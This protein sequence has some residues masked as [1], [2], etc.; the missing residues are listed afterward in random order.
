[1]NLVEEALTEQWGPK[2]SE[3]EEGCIV[4]DAW[5]EYENLVTYGASATP[6][7][8]LMVEE[9]TRPPKDPEMQKAMLKIILTE[10]VKPDYEETRHYILLK[11]LLIAIANDRDAIRIMATKKEMAEAVAAMQHLWLWDKS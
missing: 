9:M 8:N 3:Y 10:R 4:C 2:C 1:M 5:R 11:N 6:T 7:R